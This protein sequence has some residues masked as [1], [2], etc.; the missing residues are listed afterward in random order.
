[1]T[2]K[3]EKQIE[4]LESRYIV[5]SPPSVKTKKR[6]A[7]FGTFDI[8]HPAHLRFLLEARK[9]AECIDCKLVVI[10]ARDSSIERIKGHKPIF[11]EEDR[12][13]LIRSLRIVDYAQLGH[14]GTDYFEVILEVQPDKIVLG[15]DQL[16][17]EKPLLKFIEEH[18]LEIDLYRLPK[19]ESGD[20]SSSSEVRSKV[21]KL[22]EEKNKKNRI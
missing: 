1:M 8:I 13:R 7:V 9:A 17:N 19:F 18:D 20:I 6:V 22:W 5:P 2:K 21:L 11:D 3:T 10:V 4:S 12:L 16:K 14:T 15:Y